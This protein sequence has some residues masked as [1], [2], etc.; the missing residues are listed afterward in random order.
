M[1]AQLYYQ[2]LK[3]PAGLLHLYANTETLVKINFVAL[4]IEGLIEQKIP[5]LAEC[6]KQLMQFF[7]GERR[8]FNLPLNTK[9]TPF[10][11]SVWNYLRT[12][13]YG[14]VRTYKEV[15]LGCNVPKAYRAVGNACNSNPFPIIVP[16]HRVVGSNNKMGGF[17]GG[18][19]WKTFLLTTEKQK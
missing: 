17:A 10:T 19:K 2:T 18:E 1:T 7:N 5:L 12:I 14:E 15:A 16:C 4:Q 11:E 9:G 6:E 3:T 13:P 8:V